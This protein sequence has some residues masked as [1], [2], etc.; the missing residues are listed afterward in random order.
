MPYLNTIGILPFY[1]YFISMG[2]GVLILLIASLIFYR[3]ENN[4]WKWKVFCTRY[5]IHKMNK[6][7]WIVFIIVLIISM[8]IFFFVFP[9]LDKL[10]NAGIIPIPKLV[11]DWL[12][13]GITEDSERIFD[14]AVGGLKGNWLVLFIFFTGLILNIIGEELWWRGYIFP[15]QEIV[16]EKYTWIV[17]GI[18]WSFFHIFKY[19]DIPCLIILHLPFSYMVYRTKNTTTGIILHF[20][21]NGL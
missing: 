3:L 11:P 9:L 8:G 15:R 12:N 7:D 19:W 14:M 13:P 21:T 18:L 5:R 6:S 4:P 10:I 20:I 17:H 1:S 2:C 16:F